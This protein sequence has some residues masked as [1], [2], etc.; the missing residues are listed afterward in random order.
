MQPGNLFI[1]AFLRALSLPF[2]KPEAIFS[3]AVRFQALIMLGWTSYFFDSSES[4]N[5]SRIASSA[6]LALKSAE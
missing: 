4:V 5:S 2:E 3:I 6:T 1:I